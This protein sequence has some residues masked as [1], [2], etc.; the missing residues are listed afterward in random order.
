MVRGLTDGGARD[1][2][3]GPDA[4]DE[5]CI[6]FIARAGRC[7]TS[8]QASR[9]SAWRASFCTAVAWLGSV[10]FLMKGDLPSSRKKQAWPLQNLISETADSEKT[11]IHTRKRRG[12]HANA[13]KPGLLP[14]GNRH[15]P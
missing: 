13:G 2:I 5:K 14:V 12:N 10:D 8:R 7:S 9:I 11:Q 1:A 6:S 15:Q 4:T 3:D